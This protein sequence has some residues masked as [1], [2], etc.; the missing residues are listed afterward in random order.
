MSIE[1]KTVRGL[2]AAALLA[3]GGG[4]AAQGDDAADAGAE[5]LEAGATEL[6]DAMAEAEAGGEP[7]AAA[8]RPLPSEIKPLTSR[9]L[10][11]D[12]VT[13]GK[14]LFAVGDRGAIL[15]SADGKE[16]AQVQVPVRAPLTAV[17]FADADNGWAVGHDAAI[18]HTVDGGRTWA[19][20]NF[21][22]ELERPFLSV[23]ALDAQRAIAVGAYALMYQTSDGGETWNEVSASI[24]DDELHFNSIVRLA[25]GDLMIA[26]EQATLAISQ[27]QGASWTKLESPYEGSL[28]GAVALGEKGAAIFG[29]RGNAFIATDAR[30]GNWVEIK[31]DTVAS[32]F[33]GTA[34]PDGGLA[35][36]GLNG[37]IIVVNASGANA[38]LLKAPA[39]TPL[40]AAVPFGGGLLAVGESGVQHIALQ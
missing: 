23:L 14:R 26:G 25:N 10:L 9:S 15:A 16:W 20:Q 13:T 24:R 4:L 32:M 19:L 6:T 11:L 17:S 30:A 34:L 37:N 35:M 21:E 39:G 27:D 1:F 33:G 22:P 29:L 2:L 5:D 18:L 7:A 40:S 12:V 31:T 8:V 36:V 3:F 38:R 28:F